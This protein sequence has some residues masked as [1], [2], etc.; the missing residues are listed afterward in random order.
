MNKKIL[1]K[2]IYHIVGVTL[3]FNFV[4]TLIMLIFNPLKMSFSFLL[5]L[6]I[7]VIG[8]N[9][10]TYYNLYI[11]SVPIIP[12]FIIKVIILVIEYIFTKHVSV[13]A[14]LILVLMDILVI[15]SKMIKGFMFPFVK[16]E[17]T[18][19]EEVK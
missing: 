8:Y 11:D 6:Q 13:G 12:F 1:L 7:I 4:V 5:F 19:Y 3:G 10:I 18:S 17:R 15:I 9:L 16:E 2:T 14:I